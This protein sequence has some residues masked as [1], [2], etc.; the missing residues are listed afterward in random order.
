MS[1]FVI[2]AHG[3]KSPLE[4]STIDDA[5]ESGIPCVEEPLQ[6]NAL[7]CIELCYT[8]ALGL[9][10]P[11]NDCLYVDPTELP[12]P[13][14]E[15]PLFINQNNCIELCYTGC[16]G[17][18]GPNNDCLYVQQC[19]QAFDAYIVSNP[20]PCC[21]NEF[22]SIVD[23]V[24]NGRTDICVT[25]NHLIT[26]DVTFTTQ[27]NIYIRSDVILTISNNVSITAQN[28][29]DI[30]GPG[31]LRLA[32]ASNSTINAVGGILRLSPAS[33]SLNNMLTIDNTESTI[34]TD[35][36]VNTPNGG[37]TINCVNQLFMNNVTARVGVLTINMTNSGGYL[38]MSNCE[39]NA[40]NGTPDMKVTTICPTFITNSTLQSFN[41]TYNDPGPLPG[42][43]PDIQIINSSFLDECVLSVTDGL[44]TVMISN[45]RFRNRLVPANPALTIDVSGGGELWGLFVTSNHFFGDF[46]YDN[47]G[48]N[49]GNR[50][51]QID[52]NTLNGSSTLM[53]E[54][55]GNMSNLNITNNNFGDG[56]DAGIL[57][58]SSTNTGQVYNLSVQNN[59]YSNI[60]VSIPGKVNCDISHNRGNAF[61]GNTISLTFDELLGSVISYNTIVNYSSGASAS[62]LIIETND[63]IKGSRIIGNSFDSMTIDSTLDQGCLVAN[64]VYSYS[65][66]TPGTQGNF[67][68][69]DNVSDTEVTNNTCNNLVFGDAM[70]ATVIDTSLIQANFCNGGID[71]FGPISDSTFNSNTAKMDIKFN[72]DVKNCSVT[73]N[74]ADIINCI[75]GPVSS[76]TFTANNSSQMLI[77]SAT[78]CVFNSNVLTSDLTFTNHP[79]DCVISG[80][81][82][83]SI[84]ITTAVGDQGNFVTGNISNIA[85]FVA[86]EEPAGFNRPP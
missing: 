23:A 32:A 70:N 40:E 12:L 81:K 63:G 11:N 79:F 47:S 2:V 74:R 14:V 21:E 51:H 34:I 58:V 45:C 42:R 65:S 53:I 72:N 60:F 57:N 16:L 84:S 3:T 43:V 33:L 54:G 31:Q 56:N 68:F 76:N 26:G 82:T 69:N 71:V 17:L 78:G 30:W 1:K 46:K 48:G 66:V 10:G 64:N 25:V 86:A 41:I 50:A 38:F 55:S 67:I 4:P 59:S 80:N 44:P 22:A 75:T 24:S 7:G 49:T 37:G 8:G 77:F 39:G 18:T 6:V 28:R 9:T 35:I 19:T 85:G 13:C 36:D 61:A 27:G 20:N 29:L 5:R 83:P 62:T 52:G 15:E 73:S